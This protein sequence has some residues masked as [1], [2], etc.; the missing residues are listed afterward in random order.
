M[1]GDLVRSLLSGSRCAAQVGKPPLRTPDRRV[2]FFWVGALDTDM[3]GRWE[4]GS[5]PNR[6]ARQFA[7]RASL[8]TV[9]ATCTELTKAGIT[10]P[11]LHGQ[12]TDSPDVS[13]LVPAASIYFR[14]PDGHWLELICRL[15]AP[16]DPGFSVNPDADAITRHGQ[17]ANPA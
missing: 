14:G 1:N 7:F 3:L 10:P 2:A 12:P 13:G 5:G 15:D 11:D 4:I 16:A 6:M 17:P 8:P 9:L